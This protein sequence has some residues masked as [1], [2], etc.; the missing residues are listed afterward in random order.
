MSTTLAIVCFPGLTASD[1]IISANGA[2]YAQPISVFDVPTSDSRFFVS[3]DIN[4]NSLLCAVKTTS[5]TLSA[6]F[7]IA[8]TVNAELAPPTVTVGFVGGR[9]D[10]R[11]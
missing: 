7:T 3:S 4:G 6:S 8:G 1:S 10:D 11:G 2:V 9:P 5:G